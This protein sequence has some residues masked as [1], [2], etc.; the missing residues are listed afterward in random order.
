MRALEEQ[1]AAAEG[2]LREREAGFR[3]A[4]EETSRSI[5]FLEKENLE[6]MMEIKAL[7]EQIIRLTAEADALRAAVGAGTGTGNG[8]G[9]APL[10]LLAH[11]G[12]SNSG[13]VAGMPVPLPAEPVKTVAAAAAVPASGA[14]AVADKEN[15]PGSVVVGEALLRARSDD[16]T[17]PPFRSLNEDDTV[18]ANSQCKQS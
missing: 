6:L 11:A 15:G 5:R 9:K 13:V 12:G 2:K 14:M 10:A 17:A 4:E 3:A 1:V 18:N 16:E 8:T 7:K